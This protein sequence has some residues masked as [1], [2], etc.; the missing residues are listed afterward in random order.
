MYAASH[1]RSIAAMVDSANQLL[2][3]VV[4]DDPMIQKLLAR[5]LKDVDAEVITTGTAGEGFQIFGQRLPDLVIVDLRL[6][7]GSGLGLVRQIRAGSDVPIVVV[8]ANSD[9][10]SIVQCLDAGA[11]DYITK[12]FR[13]AELLARVRATLRR[14]P[15][16]SGPDRLEVGPLAINIGDR[17]VFRSGAELRLTPTE[18]RLLLQLAR[19]PNKVFTHKMLLTAVWGPEYSDEPHVL[20]VTMNRLRAKLGEPPLIENRPAVGYVLVAGNGEAGNSSIASWG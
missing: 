12:P 8:T 10:R 20:R 14:R 9:E 5:R 4:E 18:Y 17:R 6:P 3:L 13:P 7:D 15:K 2:V 11:D 16:T 1:D 19:E